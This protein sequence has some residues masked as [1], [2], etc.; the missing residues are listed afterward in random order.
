MKNGDT[1]Y[2]NYLPAA[3]KI[4]AKTQTSDEECPLTVREGRTHLARLLSNKNMAAHQK[5]AKNTADEK[6]NITEKRKTAVE[7][8][9]VYF[10]YDKNAPDVLSGFS[11]R[12]NYG[13]IFCILGENGSGKSTLLQIAAGLLRPQRGNVKIG[14]RNIQS[15]SSN[16]LYK[17][18]IGLLPQNPKAIFLHDTL[19]ADLG[20]GALQIAEKLGIEKLLDRH[21]YDLSGGEQQK[22]ALGRVLLTKPQILLLD[23]PTK[24]LDAQAKD[25]LAVIL[26]QLCD[27]GVCLIISTH[28]IEFAAE[29]A[30]RCLM[31]FDGSA[32]SF[33]ERRSFFCGNCFYTTAA[34]R[35]ARDFDSGALTC[36]DVVK[37]C[38]N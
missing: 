4:F 7:C 23:E 22:A 5:A 30:S 6:N 35:I 26:K 3:A 34:N 20:A 10:R 28:D 25:E 18:N 29:Y 19:R 13:E 14:G 36:G 8:T 11:M 21:P 32:A 27:E 16:E 38:G 2:L 1:G 33:G 37:L 17:D 12:V 15:L 9:D 31:L 24:G